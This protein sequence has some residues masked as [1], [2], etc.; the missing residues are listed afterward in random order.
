MSPNQNGKWLERITVTWLVDSTLESDHRSTTR[1]YQTCLT[2][3]SMLEGP[4]THIKR[5]KINSQGCSD[6]YSQS[7]SDPKLVPD[8]WAKRKCRCT[9]TIQIHTRHHAT[10]ALQ[11]GQVECVAN[12]A[13]WH[14]EWK[15]WPHESRS[16]PWTFSLSQQMAHS[17]SS[18]SSN[19]APVMRRPREPGSG[20]T[21]DEPDRFQ[22]D[23]T[24]SL[25][26]SM[27]KSLQFLIS[28][29]IR[30][31]ALKTMSIASPSRFRPQGPPKKKT[32]RLWAEQI[33]DG[34]GGVPTHPGDSVANSSRLQCLGGNLRPGFQTTAKTH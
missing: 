25:I 23:A 32:L 24:D 33:L 19:P 21:G 26:D 20:W 9:K 10:R 29:R 13:L 30:I 8:S 4:H 18:A 31:R 16:N 2:P 27:T 5:K 3:P 1:E 22:M 28:K 34:T 11:S 17:A 12:Q 15:A 6:M 7:L 14:A